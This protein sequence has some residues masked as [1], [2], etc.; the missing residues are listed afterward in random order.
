MSVALP[1]QTRRTW[2][3]AFSSGRWVVVVGLVVLVGL[4]V[5]LAREVVRRAQVRSV[6]NE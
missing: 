1:L 5:A 4:G 2:R 6:L 3:Y